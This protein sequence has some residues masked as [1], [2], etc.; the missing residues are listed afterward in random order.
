MADGTAQDLVVLPHQPPSSSLPCDSDHHRYSPFSSSESTAQQHD[1]TASTSITTATTTTAPQSQANITQQQSTDNARQSSAATSQEN[2]RQSNTPV[3]SLLS[4]DDRHEKDPTSMQSGRRRRSL[5]NAHVPHL[6]HIHH[7]HIAFPPNFAGYAPGHAY[8]FYPTNGHAFA[9]GRV[10]NA[11]RSDDFYSYG[12]NAAPLNGRR[13]RATATENSETDSKRSD[14][15][16]SASAVDEEGKV[17]RTG[18][19]SPPPAPYSPMAQYG[20]KFNQNARNAGF[21]PRG[22]AS[23]GE[24][25]RIVNNNNNNNNNNGRKFFAQ[26]NAILTNNNRDFYQQKDAGAIAGN[27]NVDCSLSNSAAQVNNSTMMGQQ[28]QQQHFVPPSRNNRNRRNVRRGA[29]ALSEIGAGDAPLAQADVA[30][31][32]KKLDS[33]KL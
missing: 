30:D 24:R 7:H 20:L 32:C 4:L 26:R 12:A 10:F 5:P 2:A 27:N 22:R 14:S 25:T 13:R 31:A 6:A 28:Q 3:V 11:S 15:N 16:S 21:A 23:Y 1:A 29:T 18:V 9:N 17:Q 33:L 19:T 8:N